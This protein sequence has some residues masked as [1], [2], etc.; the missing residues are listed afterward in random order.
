MPLAPRLASIACHAPQLKQPGRALTDLRIAVCL[1]SI[2][3]APGVRLVPAASNRSAESHA[4]PVRIR[5]GQAAS[6]S[7]EACSR[8]SD[9]ADAAR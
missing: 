3:L 5:I 4:R 1:L 6:T 2:V 9:A 8:V 7:L